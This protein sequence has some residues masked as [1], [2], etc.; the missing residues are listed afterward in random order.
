MGLPCVHMLPSAA[1]EMCQ[2]KRLVS[3][4]GRASWKL[5]TLLVCAK[6]CQSRLGHGWEALRLA[7]LVTAQTDVQHLQQPWPQVSPA[8]IAILQQGHPLAGCRSMAHS[9]SA[10]PSGQEG[11][12]PRYALPLLFCLAV[13]VAAGHRFYRLVTATRP[14]RGST[15]CCNET[16]WQLP[17]YGMSRSLPT[18]ATLSLS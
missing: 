8:N 1:A 14:S 18:Y 10:A 6:H 12:A 3:I 15:F 4:Y 9:A 17:T 16:F 13:Q 7:L 11:Q 5:G 2:P